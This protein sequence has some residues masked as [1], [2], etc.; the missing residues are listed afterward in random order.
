MYRVEMA[1][2][3]KQ[4]SRRIKYCVS[5]D[6]A[7]EGVSMDRTYWFYF[8]E[9]DW[10]RVYDETGSIVYEFDGKKGGKV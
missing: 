9:A 5:F 2:G 6:V 8:D 4:K 1:N 3:R 10:I 7:K